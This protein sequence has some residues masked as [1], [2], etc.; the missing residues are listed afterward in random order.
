MSS[1]S[2]MPM[3]NGQLSLQQER[4]LMENPKVL[5]WLPFFCTNTKLQIGFW[6][7]E[8]W[9]DEYT[10]Q[11][12]SDKEGWIDEFSKLDV[13][14]WADEFGDQFKNAVNEDINNGWLDDYDK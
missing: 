7:W 3:K 4:Y 10:Q 1:T 5:S 8:N 13:N 11:G 9:V 6:L 2:Q 14:D 12:T